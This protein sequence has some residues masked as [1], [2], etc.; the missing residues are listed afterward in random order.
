VATQFTL[1][2]LT[3]WFKKPADIASLHVAVGALTF[4]ATAQAVAVLAR[5]YARRTRTA[6]AD[7]PASSSQRLVVA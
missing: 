2:V 6:A 4:M 3:V 5:Q 1:G 7:V